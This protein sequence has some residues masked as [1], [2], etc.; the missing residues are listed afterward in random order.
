MPTRPPYP[1]EARIVTVEKG[2]GD[3]TVTGIN[4]VPITLNPTHS[5]V[6][7]RLN[8]KRWM[9]NGATKIPISHKC[10]PK[11][12]N[13]VPES[14]FLLIANVKQELIFSYYR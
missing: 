12:S 10:F 9:R 8:R 6:N 11:R 7:M 5:S 14:H 13:T 4:C 3:Q 1:R 2:N